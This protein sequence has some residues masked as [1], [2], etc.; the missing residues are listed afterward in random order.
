MPAAVIGLLR[1]VNVG[2]NN[3][4][5]MDLLKA[6]C[7][8][9]KLGSPQTYIQSGN[10]VFTTSERRFD[11]LS[12]AIESAIERECGFRPDVHLRSAE[13]MRAVR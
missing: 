8:S 3:L 4:I 12:Q 10:V 2:G 7:L 5:K 6:I 13:E 1:G 11:K 9:L